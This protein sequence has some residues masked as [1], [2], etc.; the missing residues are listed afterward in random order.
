MSSQG[1]RIMR[2]LEEDSGIPSP[3][4]F[5]RKK[6]PAR[7]AIFLSVLSILFSSI[8]AAFAAIV[9]TQANF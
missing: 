7:A 2:P 6:T 3:E 5:L 8:S 4:S 9:F 1:V